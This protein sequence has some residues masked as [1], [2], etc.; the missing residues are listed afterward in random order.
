M[1]QDISATQVDH[2]LQILPALFR[3]AVITRL[4]LGAHQRI[5]PTATIRGQVDIAVSPLDR[6]L[7]VGTIC[8]GG[9]EGPGLAF[10][11]GKEAAQFC[12]MTA[13]TG[14]HAGPAPIMRR[15]QRFG[16]PGA[17]VRKTGVP[18]PL[19]RWLLRNRRSNQVPHGRDQNGIHGI[20]LGP[21]QHVTGRILG[22][23]LLNPAER[24][25]KIND[26]TGFHAPI[27]PPWPLSRCT[28]RIAWQGFDQ[29]RRGP[30]EVAFSAVL[31]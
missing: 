29:G 18:Q 9:F 2:V 17:Q 13:L 27:L 31:P 26:E 14:E 23:S 1:S 24:L 15:R 8:F 6:L 28:L 25:Q 4:V 16:N 3:P 12:A 30:S 5:G 22:Q 19:D 11:I 10:R 20:G 21:R 7:N